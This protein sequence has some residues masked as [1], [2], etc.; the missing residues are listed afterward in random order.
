MGAVAAMGLTAAVEAAPIV[1]LRLALFQA[2]PDD[3]NTGIP[4]PQVG[5][6]YQL[7]QGDKFYVQLQ[8]GVDLGTANRTDSGSGRVVGTRNKPLGIASLTA[9]IKS[10]G[11]VNLIVPINNGSGQWLNY[12]DLTPEGAGFPSTNVNDRDADT[13]DDVAGAGYGL[14]FLTTGTTNAALAKVQYGVDPAEVGAQG[15]NNGPMPLVEGEYIAS[16]AGPAGL[17]TAFL[18]N[19]I[20]VDAAANDATLT[21]QS[22]VPVNEVNANV[23]I[24]VAPVPEPASLGLLAMSGLGLIRRRRNA[25]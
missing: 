15:V 4:V 13:D 12:T 25:K 21:T 14:T 23:A 10:T 16:G 1:T 24:Q 17:Q 20:Y 7:T 11:S 5:G 8:A 3:T 18:A 9:D 19:N 2:L 22:N 6:V